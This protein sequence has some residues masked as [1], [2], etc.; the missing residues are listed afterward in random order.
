[1]LFDDDNMEDG[2]DD[3]DT[4]MENV[5][6]ADIKDDSDGMDDDME[7]NTDI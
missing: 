3:V 7:D 2:D 5:E 6:D 4:D 1:M